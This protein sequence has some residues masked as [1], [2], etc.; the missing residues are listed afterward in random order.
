MSTGTQDIPAIAMTL[1]T[2]TLSSGTTTVSNSAVTSTS[3][4]FLQDTNAVL[5]NVG[6]LSVT[7]KIAGTSFTVT[8]AN[9]LDSS[10]FNY[11]I[12]G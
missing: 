3:K 12:V 10:T 6:I 8:S 9:V 5:T 1:G 4:I 11:M 2:G 7:S